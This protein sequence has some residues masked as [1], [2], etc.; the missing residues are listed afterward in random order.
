MKVEGPGAHPDRRAVPVSERRKHPSLMRR[1]LVED[2]DPAADQLVEPELRHLVS[3]I[4]LCRAQ[5]GAER[6]VHMGD[7]QPSVCQHDIG[8][9]GIDGTADE[10]ATGHQKRQHPTILHNRGP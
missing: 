1:V 5:E 9:Q 4:R 2:V 10:P 6:G 3:Q 8:L 7:P